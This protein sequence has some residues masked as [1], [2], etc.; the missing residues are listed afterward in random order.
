[1]GTDAITRLARQH[2]TVRPAITEIE[3]CAWLAQADPDDVL[4]YYRGFLL[5]DASQHSGRL[6]EQDRAELMR[7]ARRAL[8]AAN[9]GLAHLVQRRCGP[10][11]FSYLVI[12]RPRP[13]DSQSLSE[14]LAVEVG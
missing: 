8:W 2:S 11:N 9:R 14:L 10:D 1:M 3:L 12:A 7:V 6:P 5:V 4:E 13:S